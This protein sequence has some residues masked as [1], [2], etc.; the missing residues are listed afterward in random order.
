MSKIANLMGAGNVEPLPT[1]TIRMVW[2]LSVLVNFTR[3]PIGTVVL[4][5]GGSVT[6]DPTGICS[7][8]KVCAN[9]H[10]EETASEA[11]IRRHISEENM[12]HP[13]DNG[14]DDGTVDGF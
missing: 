9:A 4:A 10:E 3:D 11:I 5:V 2:G 6:S 7:R 12:K 8:D 13:I 1:G 14:F